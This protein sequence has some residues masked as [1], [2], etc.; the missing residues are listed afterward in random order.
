MRPPTDK[1]LAAFDGEITDADAMKRAIFALYEFRKDEGLEP[2]R[3]DHPILTYSPQCTGEEK[4]AKEQEL[5]GLITDRVVRKSRHLDAERLIDYTKD[6]IRHHWAD[7]TCTF[8]LA[9]S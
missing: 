3:G 5:I 4:E 6:M 2:D 1:L 8:V 9:S 7:F